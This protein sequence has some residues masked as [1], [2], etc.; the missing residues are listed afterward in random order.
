[1]LVKRKDVAMKMIRIARV[2]TS[3]MLIGFCCVGITSE[4][5]SQQLAPRTHSVTV[6][7]SFSLGDAHVIDLVEYR[8]GLT[9]VAEKV[10]PFGTPVAP[11]LKEMSMTDVYRRFAGSGV[12]VPD[13]V[14]AADARAAAT[15]AQASAA[16]LTSP[17]VR[18]T[19][20][21]QKGAA[22]D[23]ANIGTYE[24]LFDWFQPTY[25]E[26][27][28]AKECQLTFDGG[29]LVTP[30]VSYTSSCLFVGSEGNTASMEGIFYDTE[31][32]RWAVAAEDS[33]PAGWAYCYS[34]TSSVGPVWM[35]WNMWGAG[36]DA[37]VGLASYY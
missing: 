29:T 6:L 28:G 13:S 30:L 17:H 36:F 26:Q 21:G 12:T 10:P 20:R 37:T 5:L 22:H 1:V 31:F 23:R 7:A 33:I 14:I 3:S 4:A 11:E 19:S 35:Q 32:G 27:Y 25:C 24:E 2:L 15:A 16:N 34:M 8:P 18:P 9:G